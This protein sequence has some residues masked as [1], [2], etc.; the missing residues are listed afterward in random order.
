MQRNPITV[1][2]MM[3]FNAVTPDW[4]DND[5][6]AV[7][8]FEVGLNFALKHPEL[9]RQ[10]AAA[11]DNAR[12]LEADDPELAAGATEDRDLSVE[13]INNLIDHVFSEHYGSAEIIQ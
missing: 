4:I 8:G 13:Q 7:S 1:A 10:L 11:I 12:L 5:V 6:T 9:A 3:Y 2:L